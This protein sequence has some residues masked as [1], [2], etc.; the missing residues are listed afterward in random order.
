MIHWYMFII[1]LL[2]DIFFLCIQMFKNKFSEMW[3]SSGIGFSP[4]ENRVYI[5]CQEP[6]LA[7]N[8]ICK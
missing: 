6:L 8:A 2:G 7:R 4:T 3:V 5:Q 1:E